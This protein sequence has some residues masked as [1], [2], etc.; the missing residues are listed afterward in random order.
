[1][2]RKIEMGAKRGSGHYETQGAEDE[3]YKEMNKRIQILSQKMNLPGKGLKSDVS[4]SMILRP[5]ESSANI[6]VT[7]IVQKLKS[8]HEGQERNSLEKLDSGESKRQLLEVSRSKTKIL[9]LKRYEEVLK[10]EKYHLFKGK[11]FYH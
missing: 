1:M 9:G 6:L 10:S 8:I 5:G 7:G 3:K 11:N 2:K 4:K